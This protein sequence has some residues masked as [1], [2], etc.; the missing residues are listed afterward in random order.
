MWPAIIALL[1]QV[2]P[3]IFGKKYK[4]PSETGQTSTT[5][6][7]STTEMPWKGWMSPSMG[8]L[9]PMLTA[10]AMKMFQRGQGWGWPAGKQNLGIDDWI[11]QALGLLENEWPNVMKKYTTPAS[12]TT[13]PPVPISKIYQG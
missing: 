9:D 3:M 13:T 11:M 12:P 8:F 5:T 2:L 1:G 6:Q 4:N 10:A 7:T